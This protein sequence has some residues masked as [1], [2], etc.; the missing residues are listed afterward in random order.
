[1]TRMLSITLL[2]RNLRL[3]SLLWELEDF[4]KITETFKRFSMPFL[5]IMFSLYTVMFFYAVV[6][7]YFFAKMITT[8][9]V[10]ENNIS[11]SKLY[12]LI[13]FNDLY[14]SM[15]TLFHV[16]VVNNWNQTT[17]M[18]CTIAGNSWPRLY[19]STFWVICTLIMLNIVISFVLE[20][21][22]SIG[23][24]I[25]K[26][27]TKR[28]NARK[29]MKSFKDDQDG[30]E[31]YK[32]VYDVNIQERRLMY[33]VTMEGDDYVKNATEKKDKGEKTTFKGRRNSFDALASKPAMTTSADDVMVS[34]RSTMPKL[35]NNTMS[36]PGNYENTASPLISVAKLV[37]R[38]PSSG[39]R[40]PESD[41]EDERSSIVTSN[42]SETSSQ[43][44]KRREMNQSHVFLMKVIH[45][46][47]PNELLASRI[48][49]TDRENLS[50]LIPKLVQNNSEPAEI[51]YREVYESAQKEGLH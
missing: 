20:I 38:S 2:L 46:N 22:G 16:L 28:A 5:T 40:I 6:G 42:L 10:S 49:S 25:V 32:F 19:F 15:I 29:L 17:D 33:G 43:R 35:I 13:N 51:T 14:A 1:M 45:G 27:E 39:G 37:S 23:D 47:I 30:E 4:R 3:L 34:K 11:A 41:Q 21:Y 9:S 36:D 24:E 8:E 26:E 7:E 50:T 31:L 44:A 48:T 12:Y 18:Y